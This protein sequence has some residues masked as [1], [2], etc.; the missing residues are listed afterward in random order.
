MLKMD[1][2]NQIRKC[3]FSKGKNRNQIAKKHN[4]AWG[5]KVKENSIAIDEINSIG[6]NFFNPPWYLGFF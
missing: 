5:V 2:V 3:F 6:Y 1:E 4:R